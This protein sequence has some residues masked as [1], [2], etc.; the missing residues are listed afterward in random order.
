MLEKKEELKD[1]ISARK[2]QLQ[3]KL[4]ELS[5]DSRAEA[6]TSRDKIKAKLDELQEDLKDGWD[7]V[8]DKVAAKLNKWLDD[9]ES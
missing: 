7:N 3:A 6:R 2:H 8:N 4:S 1:R 9:D 5:A